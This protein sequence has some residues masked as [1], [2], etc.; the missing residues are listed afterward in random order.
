MPAFFVTITLSQETVDIM[1]PEQHYRCLES[2]YAAA[3]VNEF[4][5]PVMTVTEATAE[6]RIMATDRYHHSAGAVQ[7]LDL[8]QDAR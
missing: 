4:Y 7:R 2:M 8:F 5:K 3:P 6:I 1:S